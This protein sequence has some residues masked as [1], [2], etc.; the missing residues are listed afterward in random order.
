MY[1]ISDSDKVNKDKVSNVNNSDF[2]FLNESIN[3]HKKFKAVVYVLPQDQNNYSIEKNS[4]EKFYCSISET[5]GE[6][7]KITLPDDINKID[8]G[9]VNEATFE[10]EEQVRLKVNQQITIKNNN[11][12]VG[13][14]TITELY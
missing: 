11:K 9:Q 8:L 1:K 2:E 3:S 5:A 12:I 10:L 14:A 6:Y 13:Y 4:N 7:S